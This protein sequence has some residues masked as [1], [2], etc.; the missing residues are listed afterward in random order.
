MA[1]SADELRVLRRALAAALQPTRP[2]HEDVQDCFRL[3]RA[4]D[5]A[6]QEGG[7]LRSFLSAELVRYRAALP[8]GAAGYLERLHSA[9]DAGYVPGPDDLSA[10]RSLRAEPSGAVEARRRT[11][12]LRRCERL[13][14]LDVRARLEARIPAPSRPRLFALPG[15]K[16]QPAKPV[17]GEPVPRPKVP[18]PAEIWPRRRPGAP[19]APAPA[20]APPSEQPP[21]ERRATG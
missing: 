8:G 17:R 18:T 12:L 16:P 5:E 13:A 20:P 9:L 14:E 7:R 6:S 1:F 2:T 21:E 10:L 15:G 4:V 19:P 11:G 3:A